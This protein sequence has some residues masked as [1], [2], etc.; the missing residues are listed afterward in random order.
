MTRLHEM[1]DLKGSWCD[2]QRAPQAVTE[3]KHTLDAALRT[4]HGDSKTL[5]SAT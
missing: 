4:T 3:Q 2:A 1:G 5:Q